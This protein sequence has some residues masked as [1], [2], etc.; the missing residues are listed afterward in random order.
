[1]RGRRTRPRLRIPF[2]PVTP[3]EGVDLMHEDGASIR[4]RRP[5]PSHRSTANIGR[6]S[7]DRT[8]YNPAGLADAAQLLRQFEHA[9]LVADDLFV[10]RPFVS[11]PRCDT[12]GLRSET[13]R[14]PC[15][16]S[17]SIQANTNQPI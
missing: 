2:E 13:T 15:S 17:E 14:L 5:S 4:S 11:S 16:L 6:P 9:D 12:Q 3:G 1:M 10:P 8:S 7:D